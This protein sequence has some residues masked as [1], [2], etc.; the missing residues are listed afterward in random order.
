MRSEREVL[1]ELAHAVGPEVAMLENEL[2]QI[3]KSNGIGATLWAVSNAAG[4]TRPTGTYRLPGSGEHY[5]VWVYPDCQVVLH[6]LDDPALY[7]KGSRLQQWWRRRL[8][9]QSVPCY[10]EMLRAQLQRRAV[11]RQKMVAAKQAVTQLPMFN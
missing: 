11:Q 2:Y 9:S 6:V 5:L 1:A 4:P 3:R 8:K 10:V 7:R